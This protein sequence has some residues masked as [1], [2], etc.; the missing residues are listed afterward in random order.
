MLAH[1]PTGMGGMGM[2]SPDNIAV[3]ACSACHDRLDS[4]QIDVALHWKDISRALAETQHQW[5][6]EGLMTIK[7]VA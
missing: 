1:L 6:E 4:R 7:G 3:F 5:I 2:K